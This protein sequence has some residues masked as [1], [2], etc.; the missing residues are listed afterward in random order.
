[1]PLHAYDYVLEVDPADET[2]AAGLVF[3]NMSK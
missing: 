3:S 1:M 2:V